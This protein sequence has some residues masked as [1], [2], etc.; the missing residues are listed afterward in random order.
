MGGA[1]SNIKVQGNRILN[2]P[3][4]GHNE[5]CN[6]LPLLEVEMI[7]FKREMIKVAENGTNPIQ[8]Y[9][10]AM[11]QIPRRFEDQEII[12]EFEANSPSFSSMR[13]CLYR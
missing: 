1:C 7:S 10:Q 5:L 12:K 9:R 8:V 11:S 2:N 6:P 3:D 4:A 13:T